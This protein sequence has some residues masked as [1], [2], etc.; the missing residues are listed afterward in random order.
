MIKLTYIDKFCFC[1]FKYLDENQNIVEMLVE[2][3]VIILFP[4]YI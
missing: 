2:V 4:V 3:S 1:D